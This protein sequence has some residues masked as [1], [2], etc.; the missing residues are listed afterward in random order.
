MSV[1]SPTAGTWSSSQ[2]RPD[3]EFE[4]DSGTGLSYGLQ[5]ACRG[6]SERERINTTCVLQNKHICCYDLAAT[7]AK[8]ARAKKARSPARVARAKSEGLE[9]RAKAK[10][11][12]GRRRK[13][14]AN[15]YRNGR[16]FYDASTVQGLAHEAG[17]HV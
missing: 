17:M 16:T 15:G 14:M 6:L 2:W 9:R 7:K 10:S 4:T 5:L 12:T 1:G 13:E 3:N 8:K 11:R